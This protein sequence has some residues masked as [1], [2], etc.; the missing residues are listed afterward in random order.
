MSEFSN[1]RLNT[2]NEWYGTNIQPA[3]TQQNNASSTSIFSENT[4]DN[5]ETKNGD[6]ITIAGKEISK[7]KAIIG[8]LTIVATAIGATILI[9]KGKGK[10]LQNA[11]TPKLNTNQGIKDAAK[12]A[13][14]AAKETSEE[15]LKD[16]ATIFLNPEEIDKL[17]NW[18][19]L[20]PKIT[21]ILQGDFKNYLVKT[22][23]TRGMIE[24]IT[25]NLQNI[26]KEFT[27][28]ELEK[29]TKKHDDGNNPGLKYLVDYLQETMGRP[30]DT[31]MIIDYL[32]KIGS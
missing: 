15:T 12:M 23:K 19:T 7:K 18:D 9:F 4:I 5:K 32:H 29:I 20:D 28:A 1:V 6:T 10:M 26:S 2:F 27:P 24:T 11:S 13:E 8:G 25:K 31:K 14:T 3:I 17:I 21:K 16:I 30:K 22:P